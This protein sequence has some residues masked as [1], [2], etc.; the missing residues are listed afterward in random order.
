MF[1]YGWTE[2]E[3]SIFSPFQPLGKVEPNRMK[4]LYRSNYNFGSTFFKG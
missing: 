2:K 4:D 3:E 1:D